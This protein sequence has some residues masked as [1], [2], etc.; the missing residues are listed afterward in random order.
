MG[1]K[2]LL[3]LLKSIHRPT[4]LKKFSGE[5][6]GVDAYGWLH[7][8]AISCAIE[9][10]EGKPTRGYVDFAMKIVRM[11]MHFGVT[12]YMVFDGDF[13]PSK[14][15]TEASRLES[16]EKRKALGMELLKA[17]KP[18]QAHQE[19]QKAIDVTP[20]MARHL[21]EA[22]KQA[23]VPYVVAPY[24]ADAQMVYLERQ[25]IISGIISED[26]DLLIF[27]AKRLITK[28]NHQGECV[29]IN[30]RDFGACR[31]VSLTSWT[32][33]SFRHMG[34]LSGCDYLGGLPGM[35]LKTAHRMLRKHRSPERV[36]RMIQFEGKHSVPADY[37]TLFKQAEQTFLY[38]WV[39]CPTAKNLVN[40][41]PL[42][43]GVN[44][45]QLPFIGKYVEPELAQKIASGEYNPMTKQRI[46]IESLPPPPRK[47][48]A[49][50]A[51]RSVIR[52]TQRP[53][54][55]SKKPI[56]A[57]FKGHQR[58]ALGEMDPNCFVP[59]P[60]RLTT[61]TDEGARPVIF[62]LPRPYIEGTDPR[63]SG[64]SRTYIQR[65]DETSRILRRRTEP[66]SNLL[67]NGGRSL[68]AE[69]RRLTAGPEMRTASQPEVPSVQTGHRPLKKARLCEDAASGL[70]P[71]KEKSKF[72]SPKR[73]RSPRTMKGAGYLMSDDSIEEALKDLP[74]V[75]EWSSGTT[76][77]KSI[78]VYAESTHTSLPNDPTGHG[79]VVPDT[80]PKSALNRFA[81][82]PDAAMPETSIPKGRSRRPSSMSST[83]SSMVVSTPMSTASQPSTA[84]TTPATPRLSPL[85][86]L[87]I[88]ALS[89][90]KA[91][92]TPTFVK[93]RQPKRSSLGRMSLDA[94]PVN[95]A[96][97]P[98]PPVDKAEKVALNETVGSED[99]LV[100]GSES[101]DVENSP[102]AAARQG[103]KTGLDLSRFRL[104]YV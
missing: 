81:Y 102:P 53:R 36:I 66:I 84:K 74:D 93:P 10:A 38:Q 61:A 39:F 72:F 70:S 47:R 4:Q 48:T 60:N 1:I 87:G 46:P 99:L 8:G 12:P 82:A 41:T 42:P 30:R 20:E 13:L 2:G 91:S 40:L 11:V 27:G 37:L 96:F 25:G 52:P 31:E 3:P 43:D 34:I 49:S 98:L 83:R 54:E 44:L 45:E 32:D 88:Q 55:A 89:R 97:V 64:T 33:E 73:T 67:A 78:S 28:L 101:D 51:D 104:S 57:Y 95:P 14:A 6:F 24:E 26:S 59:D 63:T 56:D 79:S 65:P 19:L 86:R 23:G 15:S 68:A 80:P 17:G 22:L 94:M 29:E 21:I 103:A 7:R 100:P 90:G 77:R 35:G 92:P 69:S 16:R 5:T 58:I 85:E 62:P 18:S 75:D 50:A 71:R 9:L 76:V